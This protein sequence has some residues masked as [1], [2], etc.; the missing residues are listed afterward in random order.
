MGGSTLPITAAVAAAAVLG[1]IHTAAA[2]TVALPAAPPNILFVVVDD[3][4]YDVRSSTLT[5]VNI[6][7]H[8]TA[9]LSGHTHTRHCGARVVP[10]PMTATDSTRVVLPDN[11]CAL[12]R[13]YRCNSGCISHCVCP[14]Q[15]H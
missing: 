7:Q 8:S 4:G 13:V 5:S 2:G 14:R 11:I 3:L 12:R 10:N 15:N 6:R 9:V 1:L